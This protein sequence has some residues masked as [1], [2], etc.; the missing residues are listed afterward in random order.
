[1]GQIPHSPIWWGKSQLRQLTS[2]LRS[3]VQIHQVADWSVCPGDSY[4]STRAMWVLLC[5]LQN[6]T[7]SNLKQRVVPNRALHRGLQ[8]L[9]QK[10]QNSNPHSQRAPTPTDTLMNTLPHIHSPSHIFTVT[11]V[12][13]TAMLVVLMLLL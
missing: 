4:P 1:M 5:L 8:L 10:P 7:L 2:S 13:P 3:I 11:Q 6:G 9:C 12:P